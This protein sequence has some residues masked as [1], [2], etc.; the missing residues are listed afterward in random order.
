VIGRRRGKARARLD[1]LL[2]ATTFADRIA[3]KTLA[4]RDT[5][6]ERAQLKALR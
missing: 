2:Q 6:R 4:R 5:K 1:S 3:L